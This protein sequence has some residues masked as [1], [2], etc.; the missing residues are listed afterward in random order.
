MTTYI[1]YSKSQK[2]DLENIIVRRGSYRAQID[3]SDQ[4]VCSS[5]RKKSIDFIDTNLSNEYLGPEH[6]RIHLD[7]AR[8][9]MFRLFKPAGGVMTLIVTRRIHKAARYLLNHSRTQGEPRNYSKKIGFTHASNY[10]RAFKSRL[11]MS[12][13][14]YLL[15]VR[16]GD[17]NWIAAQLAEIE[18]AERRLIN[19][20]APEPKMPA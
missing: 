14:Q 8:S 1:I 20:E 18:M 19:G 17:C 7:L 5:L 2:V 9:V 6:L 4:E 12:P 3:Q 16:E 10:T 15:R 11:N 13:R